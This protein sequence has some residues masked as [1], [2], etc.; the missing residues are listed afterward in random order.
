MPCF[1]HFYTLGDRYRDYVPHSW[2]FAYFCLTDYLPTIFH[3]AS[4]WFTVALAAHR[5]VYVC[6]PVP[7]KR[8]CT[9]ANVL[10]LIGIIYFVAVVSHLWRFFEY[11]YLPVHVRPWEEWAIAE[12]GEFGDDNVDEG[13]TDASQRAVNFTTSWSSTDNAA[14]F[15]V[16][17]PGVSR[18]ESLLFN[19]YYGFRVIC[20][21]IVPCTSLVVLNSALV[22]AIRT[23]QHRHRQLLSRQP[24]TAETGTSQLNVN[25]ATPSS[26]GDGSR[27]GQRRGRAGSDRSRRQSEGSSTTMMLVIVVSVF[28]LV[29]TPLA[30]LLVVMIAENTFGAS[31]LTTESRDSASLYL[32]LF[33]LVSYPVNFFIYCAMSEQFRRTFCGLF[34]CSTAIVTP[35]E[36]AP[37]GLYRSENDEGRGNVEVSPVEYHV[38]MVSI[39]DVNRP[40]VVVHEILQSPVH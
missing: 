26:Q 12:N 3:T 22:G 8:L 28:L 14:C 18:H 5:Y 36:S 30:I 7:A 11:Q 6:H 31:V 34:T 25:Q 10:W 35:P 19:T 27:R 13:E 29:E 20:V 37:G 39:V 9:M 1:L 33:T 21:H 2:C 40:D 4:V 16:F 38:E 32:N 24:N 15:Y 23:A 17:S